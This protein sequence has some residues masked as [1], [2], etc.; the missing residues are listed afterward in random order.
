MLEE[1]ILFARK[2]AHPEIGNLIYEVFYRPEIPFHRLSEESILDIS[3]PEANEPV[4]RVKEELW[5]K[6]GV[7]IVMRKRGKFVT[8]E[9]LQSSADFLLQPRSSEGE[10]SDA[11]QL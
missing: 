4:G 10:S 7:V 9:K 3:E 6:Y 8:W 11:T 2:Y 1:I 5:R